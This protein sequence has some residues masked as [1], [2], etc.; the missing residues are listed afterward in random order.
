MKCHCGFEGFAEIGNFPDERFGGKYKDIPPMNIPYRCPKCKTNK[1]IEN[2]N[3]YDEILRTFLQP[4]ICRGGMARR[5]HLSVKQ[6]VSFLFGGADHETV[7]YSIYCPICTYGTSS[8][9]TKEEHQE[10]IKRLPQK[11]GAKEAG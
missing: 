11:V 3:S 8:A 4:S 6:V 10:I 9:I 1:D 2:I 7:G 5:K